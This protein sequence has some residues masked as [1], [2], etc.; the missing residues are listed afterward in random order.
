MVTI[1]SSRAAVDSTQAPAAPPPPGVIPD[2][3]SP[4]NYKHANIILHSVVLSATTIAVLIRL[5]TRTFI[6]KSIGVDDWLAL[7]SWALALEFSVVMAY[8]ACSVFYTVTFFVDLFRCWPIQATW[9]PNVKGTCMSYA[10]F[11]NATGVFNIIP[12]FFILWIPLPPV[13][14]MNMPLAR[15]IRIA[16]TFGL[17]LFIPEAN[18][19]LICAYAATFHAFFDAGDPR[20]LGSLVAS[21]LADRS[22]SRTRVGAS[23]EGQAG[24]KGSGRSSDEALRQEPRQPITG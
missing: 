7:L 14:R 1:A 4:D 16:L 15:K 13:L 8:G 11:P 10:A 21:L 18:V 22:L 23:S 2:F 9:D 17:G 5:Y 20:S 6:K 12:D 3:Q 19:G 24:K